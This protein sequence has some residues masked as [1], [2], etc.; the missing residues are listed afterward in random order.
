MPRRPRRTAAVT[1]AKA[2][3]AAGQ[4]VDVTDRAAAEAHRR[5]RQDWQ[6][7][8]WAF[9]EATGEV[10]YSLDWLSN[11]VS[12]LRFHAAVDPGNGDVPVPVDE[13][14]EATDTRPPL[15]TSVEAA[16]ATDELARLDEGDDTLPGLAAETAVHFNVPGECW[17]VVGDAGAE[18]ASTDEVTVRDGAWWIH[19][20]PGGPAEP[21]TGVLARLWVRHRRW[22]HL[23]WSPLLPVLDTL[24]ELGVISRMIRATARSRL[25]AGI[26]A[27]PDEI[28]FPARSGDEDEALTDGDRFDRDL[29]DA[30]TTAV[31]DEGSASAVVPLTV[32][33]AGEWVD[34]IRH[35]PLGRPWDPAWR[36]DREHLMRR[37]A[38]GLPVPAEIVTGLAGVNHWSAWLVDQS[39]YTAHVEP[40]AM[41]IARALTR[42]W[43]RPALEERG[44]VRPDVARRLVV[45]FDPARLQV[46]PDRAADSDAGW[47]RGLISDTAWRAVRGFTD[48][49]APD[50][51]ELFARMVMQGRMP[52]EV[53]AAALPWLFPD[54][55]VPDRVTVT[56]P[57]GGSPRVVDV[58][59]AEPT[60]GPPPDGP[61]SVTA[62]LSA[63]LAGVDQ[64]LLER[65]QAAVD[66]AAARITATV[67]P[68][69]GADLDA[70]LTRE[71]AELEPRV[72]AWLRQ[73][74]DDTVRL[75]AL[76]G[77]LDVDQVDVATVDDDI[78]AGWLLLAAGFTAVVAGRYTAPLGLGESPD[79]MVPP[80]VVRAAAARA[81]GQPVDVTDTGRVVAG[82]PLRGLASGPRAEQVARTAGLVLLGYRW[83]YGDPG[84]RRA[85]F[86]PHWALDGV[87]FTG[88]TDDVL[89]TDGSGA[90]WVGAWFAPG[91]HDGCQCTY[92]MVFGGETGVGPGWTEGLDRDD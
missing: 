34:K 68:S 92:E 46:R 56:G 53:A 76:E 43:L 62:G 14:T 79:G 18:I 2:L 84:S 71:L 28:T 88:W 5:R 6:S 54:V 85:N 39:A 26:L 90:E 49:D 12:K 9:Y 35:I 22:G 29:I 55:P 87:V 83:V 24:D 37:L 8:A 63:R 91:D 66:R 11:A 81:G 60:A 67:D 64:R 77:T 30:M 72:R 78:S 20:E 80:V 1:N 33:A 4:R 15:L 70:A 19:R 82:E 47:D 74:W 44:G 36:D 45:W 48:S 41:L 86:E 58:P 51:R 89:R 52:V 57:Q 61:P 59:E 23:A 73:G 25:S 40:Q 50:D 69:S 75:L 27:M 3:V 65:I 16:I 7:L 10:A 21:V 38:Q 17:L 13:A 31:Q 32:R 42:A